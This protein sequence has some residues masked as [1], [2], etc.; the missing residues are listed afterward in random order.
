MSSLTAL[1]RTVYFLLPYVIHNLEGEVIHYEKFD[2]RAM[3]KGLKS[4]FQVRILQKGKA[5]TI[6][7][8]Q[9]KTY[10]FI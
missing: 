2:K 5:T 7:G 4:Q 1:A 6:L 9:Q 8:S 3:R 10:G